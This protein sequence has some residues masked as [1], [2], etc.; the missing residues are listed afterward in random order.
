[1]TI[2]KTKCHICDT[3][4]EV[5]L[6]EGRVNILELWSLQGG[7][8]HDWSG[9][10]SMSTHFCR[11]CFEGLAKKIHRDGYYADLSLRRDE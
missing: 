8:L 4:A 10:G 11:K 2:D 1:M 9:G 3:E 7:V 6:N 5:V